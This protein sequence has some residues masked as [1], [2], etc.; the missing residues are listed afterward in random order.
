MD[1]ISQYQK[2][3]IQSGTSESP[4]GASNVAGAK[5]STAISGISGSAAAGSVFEATVT[6]VRNG[7]A[8]LL[9]SNGQTISAKI[10]NSVPLKQGETMLFE[11]KSGTAEQTVIRPV[12]LEGAQNPTLSSALSAAGLALNQRNLAM[13]NSM[14]QNQMPIDKASLLSMARIAQ[15]FSGVDVQSLVQM[16]NLGF[17]INESMVSQFENYKQGQTSLLTGL[18]QIVEGLPDALL[19]GVRSPSEML[20]LT[21][22]L[23]SAP[24]EDVAGKLFGKETTAE[25]K[26]GAVLLANLEGAGKGKEAAALLANPELAG[27]GKEAA[28]LLANLELAGKGK[29][30]AALL[31]TLEGAGKGKDAATLLTNLELAGKGKEA[32][33]LLANLEQAIKSGNSTAEMGGGIDNLQ[34]KENLQTKAAV[35][36]GEQAALLQEEGIKTISK[37]Q[38][39]NPQALGNLLSGEQAKNLQEALLKFPGMGNNKEVFVNGALNTNLEPKEL[40]KAVFDTLNQQGIQDPKLLADLFSRKEFKTLLKEGIQQQWLLKPADVAQENSV[41]KLY[42]RMERGMEHLEEFLRATGQSN[43]AAGKSVAEVRSNLEF[44]NQVNNLYQFVQLPLKMA[45]QN[46]HADLYVY[47]NKKNLRNK[48]GELTAL[49]HLDLEHLGTTDV[50]IKLFGGHVTTNFYLSDDI[51]HRLI[52]EHSPQLERRL[53]EM[54]YP[55]TINMQKRVEKQEFVEDFLEREKHVG[56]LKRYSFDMMA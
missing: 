34:G 20:A 55:C 5:A 19:K 8:Q 28:A 24:G 41:Q 10:E 21:E 13:V 6:R 43:S 54:G 31:A 47:T 56:K 36:T 30:A 25:S 9:L 53:E 3:T 4:K 11:V 40:L 46:A 48:E 22:Q 38:P 27:K 37:E 17:P 1:G 51:A 16:K 18:G 42:E 32:A 50:H 39:Q 35:L 26:E 14:M 45:N 12:S 29:E 52:K 15:N 2:S 7:Q 33:T 44:M 23:L 49:L